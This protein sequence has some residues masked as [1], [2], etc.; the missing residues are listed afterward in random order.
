M[1]SVLIDLIGK[2]FGRLLVIKRAFPNICKKA[3]W[4]CRCDCGKESV[5]IGVDLRNGHT[6][7]CGCLASEVVSKRNTKH[8]M[9]GDAEHVTW[10]NMTQRATNKNHPQF[11]DYGGRGIT[12]CE[13][14]SV[15][16]NFFAD[17]GKKPGKGYSIERIENDLGYSK[18][19][20]KWAT[21][22]E[23][24]NNCRTSRLITFNGKTKNVV[25]WA[26]DIG[27]NH[28]TLKSRLRSGWPIE[29]ALTTPSQRKQPC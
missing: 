2:K 12:V 19:N 14:W 29:K 16:E 28:G 4:I 3:I 1:K 24:N 26:S 8:G 20:C 7:S 13:R 10:K 21:R 27:M 23:Q 5:A 15:F 9:S 17:M 11:K 22:A 18:E 25:T 6:R